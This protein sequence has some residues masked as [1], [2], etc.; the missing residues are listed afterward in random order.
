MGGFTVY[1]GLKT[2]TIPQDQDAKE[3]DSSINFLLVSESNVL[4]ERV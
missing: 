1:S 3:G 2:V 4:V